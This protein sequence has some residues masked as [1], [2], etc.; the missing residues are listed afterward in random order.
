MN[1][2]FLTWERDVGVW[3]RKMGQGRWRG[4][5]RHRRHDKWVYRNP[6]CKLN[7]FFMAAPAPMLRSSPPLLLPR[8]LC[9]DHSSALQEPV[10]FSAACSLIQPGPGLLRSWL[11]WSRRGSSL[12]HVWANDHHLSRRSNARGVS[13]NACLKSV[14]KF[15]GS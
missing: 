3:T 12:P 4:E 9:N 8:L 10:P 2:P 15:I 7:L 11:P 1:G 13:D 5:W 6:R 14:Q